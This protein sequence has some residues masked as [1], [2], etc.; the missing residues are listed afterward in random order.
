MS[1][2]TPLNP[3]FPQD[4]FSCFVYSEADKHGGMKGEECER[5][6]RAMGKCLEENQDYYNRGN[7]DGPDLNKINEEVG[8]IEAQLLAIKSEL[9]S[10]EQEL[11]HGIG[12]RLKTVLEA[13]A[14]LEQAEPA[15]AAGF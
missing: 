14:T 8:E 9:T 5:Q 10:E 6:F 11:V 15:P 12:L 1:V 13:T 7:D 3:K 4:A 2:F